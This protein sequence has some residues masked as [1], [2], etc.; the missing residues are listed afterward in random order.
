MT[1]IDLSVW[2]M[3]AVFG[4]LV[5]PL[6]LVAIFCRSLLWDAIWAMARM[7]AQLLLVGVYLKFVFEI[8]SLY[9]NALWMLVA[10]AVADAS[11]LKQARLRWRPFVLGTL[12]GTAIAS[13]AVTL[14][15][16]M[17]IIQPEPIYDARYLIP[18]FGMTL[19]N[20][21]RGNVIALER[22]YHGVRRNEREFVNRLLLGASRYE[23]IQPFMK[24][25]LVAALG[26]MV[27]TMATMGIVALPGMMTGQILGG[28]LPLLAIKYQ[29]AIMICIFSVMVTGAV[30]N[31]VLTVRS[32]FDEFG[33]LRQEIFVS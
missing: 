16:V 32:G 20:C 24:D 6:G 25:A 15:F 11:I 10:L 21:L 33:M 2:Q 5:L 23:S 1:T 29:I 7:T 26:P 22:F 9:L 4:L 13:V 30:L 19:G 18:I 31:L 14:I 8:N 17:G 3:V 12:T 28:S 27:A